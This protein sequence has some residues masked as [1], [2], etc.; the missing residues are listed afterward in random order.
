M[1]PE[2]IFQAASAIALAGWFI[3]FFLSPFWFRADRFI[4]GIVVALLALVYAWLVIEHFRLP[5]FSEFFT[6]DGIGK[7]FSNKYLLA[8][9][10]VH[11]LA[12]DLLAGTWIKKNSFRHGI[13][14]LLTTVC[15]LLTFLLAPLGIL[16]YLVI[17]AARV[18]VYFTEN[19]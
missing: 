5:Y 12:I 3:L 11:Y 15:L 14:H 2:L 1:S 8:A 13:P 10:W 9:G 7:L 19:F 17:R 18:K 6:L 16:V 4:I